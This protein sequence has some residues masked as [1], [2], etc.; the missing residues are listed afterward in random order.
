MASKYEI[1]YI[2]KYKNIYVPENVYKLFVSDQY[3]LP[4][5]SVSIIIYM[6]LN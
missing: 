5:I 6:I 1:N 3:F 2:Q 4:E